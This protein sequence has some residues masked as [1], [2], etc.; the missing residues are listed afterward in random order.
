M[1]RRVVATFDTAGKIHFVLGCEQAHTANLLE[2]YVQRVIEFHYRGSAGAL[3]NFGFR[4]TVL[5]KRCNLAIRQPM[6]DVQL[7][8]C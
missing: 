6:D 8:A 2:V 7:L 3:A 4:Q 1:A 5:A